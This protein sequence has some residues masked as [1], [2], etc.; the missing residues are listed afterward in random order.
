[1][2]VFFAGETGMKKRIP[3]VESFIADTP[4]KVENEVIVVNG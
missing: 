2:V 1:V 3:I 4:A